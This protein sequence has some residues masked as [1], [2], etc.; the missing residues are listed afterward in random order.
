M[1]GDTFD[2]KKAVEQ[3]H[4]YIAG[5]GKDASLLPKDWKVLYYK[6]KVLSTSQRVWGGIIFGL[7]VFCLV[8][9]VGLLISVLVFSV[10][11]NAG[12]VPDN[13]TLPM[14]LACGG[15]G[16]LIGIAAFLLVVLTKPTIKEPSFFAITKDK[17]FFSTQYESKYSA[18]PF[19][20]LRD[21]GIVHEGVLHAIRFDLLEGGLPLWIYLLFWDEGINAL[22]RVFTTYKYESANTS[23]TQTQ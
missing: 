11:S 12:R 17:V 15:L 9:L 5:D 20:I 8:G 14:L 2:L 7:L 18:V 1:Q 19:S 6:E 13:Y 22:E 10:G 21:V 4:N 3:V 16:V 23:N